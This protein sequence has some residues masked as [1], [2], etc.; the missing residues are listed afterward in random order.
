M[1]ERQVD[2]LSYLK[3]LF[4]DAVKQDERL[5][6]ADCSTSCRGISARS[7]TRLKQGDL[8]I[9]AIDTIRRATGSEGQPCGQ[10]EAA[11]AIVERL[12]HMKLKSNYF[13]SFA[14]TPAGHVAA[15]LVRH[16][17]YAACIAEVLRAGARYGFASTCTDEISPQCSDESKVLVFLHNAPHA[18]DVQCGIESRTCTLVRS[19]LLAVLLTYLLKHT[20]QKATLVTDA[21]VNG[22]HYYFTRMLLI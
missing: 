3:E 19:E 16:Q 15:F 6:T 4:V 22:G 20:G 17:V 9:V 7:S 21:K 10:E 1:A 8:V 12:S 5:V 2:L 14:V 13:Q 18:V 11:K